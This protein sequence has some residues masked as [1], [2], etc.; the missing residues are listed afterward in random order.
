[1]YV[2][3]DIIQ[4]MAK[5]SSCRI[6]IFCWHYLDILPAESKQA[7]NSSIGPKNLMLCWLSLAQL[8]PLLFCIGFL[9]FHRSSIIE[10][11]IQT[12]LHVQDDN[13]SSFNLAFDIY[14]FT[15]IIKSDEDEK[16]KNTVAKVSKE[17]LSI[18]R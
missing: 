13:F 2:Y 11:S 1:M 6:S 4:K 9:G 17:S 18:I 5:Y 12:C 7:K 8:S 16:K 10:V 14:S 3:K 15:L